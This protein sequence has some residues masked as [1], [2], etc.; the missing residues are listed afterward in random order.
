MCESW[1]P[2]MTVLPPRSTTFV[3]GP[4][5]DSASALVPTAMS[6]PSLIASA[7]AM[8]KSLSTVAMW[9]LVRMRSAYGVQAGA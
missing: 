9:P 8:V 6:R 4:R 2:G 5:C 1:R 3:A 7:W